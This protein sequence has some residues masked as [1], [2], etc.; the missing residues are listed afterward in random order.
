VL[1]TGP[2]TYQWR[3]NNANLLNATNA[4]YTVSNAQMTNAGKYMVK[5]TNSGGAV[6]SPEITLSVFVAPV[7][8]TG[9]WDFNDASL[10]ATLG[11]DLEYYR[12]DVQT[13]TQFG[14]TASLGIPN[15]GDKEAQVMVVPELVPMFG[16]I[17]RH[18]ALANGGGEYVNQYTLI[19]DVLYPASADGRWRVFLQTAADNGNDGDFFINPA[20][21]IGISG[22]YQGTILPDTWYRIALAVDLSGPGPAPIVAKFIN[23][24]KVG[25]QVLDA[26]TDGRWSL[27]PATDPSTPY[28]LLFA[29]NDGDNAM[30]YVNSVQFWSG[31]LSDAAIAA[32]GAPT[33]GGLPLPVTENPKLQ[34]QLSGS[35]IVLSWPLSAAG[36]ILDGTTTLVN[37]SWNPV[38]DGV[39]ATN[40]ST[41][42]VTVPI[43]GLSRYFKLKQ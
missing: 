24:V 39:R 26:G 35:Q 21:G 3:F 30:T 1:G 5:V 43:E 42:T 25:E 38:T 9:Q 33:A 10:K 18:G 4:T 13:S 37:P 20:G 8:L 17:M 12:E 40:G 29:D 2:F 34:A 7:Q 36:F 6:D 19:M 31:R 15:I 11:N 27:Y 23:G 28:A 22:N 16:Y 32:L 14:S 41:I